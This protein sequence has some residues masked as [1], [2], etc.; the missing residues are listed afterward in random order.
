VWPWLQEEDDKGRKKERK[1]D[2]EATIK[3]AL[4]YHVLS[5]S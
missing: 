1:K 2:E 4:S 5:V 3:E